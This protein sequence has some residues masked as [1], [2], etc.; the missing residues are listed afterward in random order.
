MRESGR[1]LGGLAVLAALLV[2][3]SAS[4]SG[5]QRAEDVDCSDFPN[6][7][8]A[9]RYLDKHG[10]GDPAGLDGDRDGV[11]CESSPCPCARPG[12][13]GGGGKGGGGTS[14]SK[15]RSAAQVV[16]VTDGDTIKALQGRNEHYVRLIGIDTPEVYPKRECGGREATR[17]MEKLLDPGDR[18]KLIRDRTQDNNR[19]QYGRLL[20]YVQSGKRDLGRTQV[21][22]GLAQVYVF[23][24][25]FKR[26]GSYRR[27]R[28]RA[29]HA[30]R[31]S[32]KRCRGFG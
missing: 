32:W 6:Q 25:P 17:S 16:S 2:P 31:G 23:D 13:G 28:K 24:R 15:G 18:V 9:Q 4:A 26:V 21:H 19:D 30:N 20:R 22:K 5:S 29:K 3:A 10:L 12:S 1:L 27:E 8:A 11:A 14:G 7:A